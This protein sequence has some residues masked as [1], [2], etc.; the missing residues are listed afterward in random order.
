MP[1]RSGLDAQL[2]QKLFEIGFV[3]DDFA[4]WLA[5]GNGLDS[6]FVKGLE[7]AHFGHRVFFGTGKGATVLSGPGFQGGLVDE[8]FKGE[9]RAAVGSYD[10]GEFAA[11]TGA[12]VGAITFEKIILIDVAVGGGV[13]L[14]AANGIGTSHRRIIGAQGLEVNE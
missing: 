7:E 6:T 1:W 9:G 13:A 3:D 14:N 4:E 2:P 8:D 12:A 11:R 5:C 10:V